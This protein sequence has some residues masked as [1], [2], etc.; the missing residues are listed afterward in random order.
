MQG[1]RR[2]SRCRQPLAGCR[3]R[4]TQQLRMSNVYKLQFIFD[5]WYD[6]LIRL[7]T[8]KEDLPTSC[9]YVVTPI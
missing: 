4:A 3:S 2:G 9:D 6:K 7:S 5:K 1:A 8:Q